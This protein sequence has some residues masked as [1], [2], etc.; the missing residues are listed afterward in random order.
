MLRALHRSRKRW[1]G[2]ALAPLKLARLCV[3][4]LVSDLSPTSHLL[5]RALIRAGA[6]WPGFVPV[7]DPVRDAWMGSSSP[8]DTQT[9]PGAAATLSRFEADGA[10]GTLVAKKM[11]SFGHLGELFQERLDGAAPGRSEAC[12]AAAFSAAAA[13]HRFFVLPPP[14]PESRS[15][16][17]SGHGGGLQGQASAS[18]IADK[19]ANW[20][21]GRRRSHDD[22]FGILLSDWCGPGP[23]GRSLFRKV[24]GESRT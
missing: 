20:K 16:G 8:M 14:P 19:L 22:S 1:C 2:T 21:L 24:L 7:A 11:A 23:G 3:W 17:S 6:P 15:R 10:S 5:S 18:D 12:S 13:V 4:L 9:S